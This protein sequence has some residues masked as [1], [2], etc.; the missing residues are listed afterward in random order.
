MIKTIVIPTDGSNHAGKAVELGADIA[1][2][3]G[4]RILILHV[5]MRH[6]SV[7]DVKTLC[8]KIGAPKALTEGLRE[9]ERA[10]LDAAMASG[11]DGSAV[12]LP[13]PHHILRRIGEFIVDRAVAAARAKGATVVTTQIIDGSPAE[14]I[15]AAAETEHADM[16]VMGSRGLGKFADLFM[17][18]VSHKVSHLSHCT[19]VTVK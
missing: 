4:A 13:T 3:Y 16:I 10:M 11:S 2:K 12:M 1:G 18:G 7:T 15:L 17:G 9:L 8:R 5:L 14:A 19:C 6:M